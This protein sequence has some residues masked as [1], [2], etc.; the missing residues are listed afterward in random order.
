[1]TCEIWFGN[2]NTGCEV[3]YSDEIFIDSLLEQIEHLRQ[4]YAGQ[5]LWL[6]IKNNS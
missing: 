6:K 3:N 2:N 5:K 4:D 1:M